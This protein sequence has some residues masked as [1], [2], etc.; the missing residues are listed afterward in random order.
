MDLIFENKKR[1]ACLFLAM[2]IAVLSVFAPSLT[3]HAEGEYWPAG[4]DVASLSAIVM[5]VETGTVLYEKAADDAHYPASITKIMTALIAIEN[6]DMD[7]VVTFSANAVYSVEA[8]SSSIARDVGEEMTM[9]Q[10]LYGMLLESANECANAIAEHVAGDISSFADMMNKKATE[11]GCTNTHF[12]NANGLP[13]EEHYISARDMAIISS[14][15]YKNDTFAKIVG[16][17]TYVIPPTNKHEEETL[18]N[19]HHKMLHYYKTRKYIYDYCVGGKTGYTVAANNTLVTYARKDGMTLVCVVMC[20]T[21]PDHWTDTRALF[22]YCFD[23]F[24]TY[25]VAEN[26]DILKDD[27][28]KDIGTLGS[29]I[30]LIKIDPEG[31]I[32]L[33][34]A[35]G[36]SDTSSVIVEASDAENPDVVGSIRYSY[37][38]RT[39]GAAN[40]LYTQS[41]SQSYP[42]HNIETAEGDT[43]R[44]A[45]DDGN[46]LT[47][48]LLRI[49]RYVVLIAAAVAALI[50]FIS[51][52]GTL[53]E[54]YYRF[55]NTHKKDPNSE[56]T[57]ID[58]AYNRRDRRRRRR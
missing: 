38:D 58:R 33:P 13:D 24:A 54:K 37:G 18:L 47:I 22:D 8:G 25:S 34:K 56:L 7:E 4:I 2:M 27:D 9:E 41:T 36:F 16:T 28:N 6:C 55:K 42:F 49:V 11:L 46:F 12:V 40:L 17:K 20:A 53:Q 44:E 5:E 3:V 26:S 30:D 48:D 43:N 21:S 32:V 50:F 19:N 57:R 1:I 39:V 29:Q 35:A 51:K 52:I 15:A 31:V 23:N 10:C 14:E 45:S